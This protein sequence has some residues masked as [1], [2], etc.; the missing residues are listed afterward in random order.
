VAYSPDGQTVLTGSHDNTARLWDAK[1]GKPL[2]EPLLHQDLVVAVA[3]S[4]D[5][6][7]V[8]TGSEDKSARLWRVPPPAADEP[9]RLKLSVEVRTGYYLDDDG[10]RRELTYDQWLDRRKTLDELGGFCDQRTWDQVSAAE[11]KE[12]RTPPK[13]R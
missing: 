9:E 13:A 5:G 1:T 7:T 10:I 11:K 4:P 6:Q 3:Y 12:L 8:L 2:H